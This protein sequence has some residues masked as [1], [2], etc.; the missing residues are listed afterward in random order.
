MES[1]MFLTLNHMSSLLFVLTRDGSS[2]NVGFGLGAEISPV[3][4]IVVIVTMYGI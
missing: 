1:V 3:W 4:W 2:G